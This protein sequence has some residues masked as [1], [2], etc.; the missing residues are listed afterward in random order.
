MVSFIKLKSNG[1]WG[2]KIAGEDLKTAAPG[3]VVSVLKRDGTA[4]AATLVALQDAESRMRDLGYQV[5]SIAEARPAGRYYPK[6]RSRGEQASFAS[7][8]APYDLAPSRAAEDLS[9][10]FPVYTKA[11]GEYVPKSAY[12]R[13]QLR[14]AEADADL[15]PEVVKAEA[16]DPALVF[17]RLLGG[18]YT[19]G[20]SVVRDIRSN[21]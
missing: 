7:Q 13:D 9:R 1:M 5:W 6:T 14:M 21:Q 18:T 2:V 10:A 19:P 12:E 17:Q 20:E 15:A 8:N 11:E 4:K 3:S 16:E